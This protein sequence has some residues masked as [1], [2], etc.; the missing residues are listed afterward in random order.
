[1]TKQ[2]LRNMKMMMQTKEVNGKKKNV[3]VQQ[4]TTGER[5]LTAVPG[6][7][8]FVM[9]AARLEVI[10]ARQRNVSHSSN[11]IHSFS[12]KDHNT[13]RCSLSSFA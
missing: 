4:A 10:F 13:T 9:S 7:V 2:E 3:R 12:S 5:Q 1:M 11:P 8:T 6:S